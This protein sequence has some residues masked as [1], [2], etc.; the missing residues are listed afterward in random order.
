V[1]AAELLDRCRF[2]DTGDSTSPLALGVSGGADSVAMALLAAASGRPFVIWHVDHGLR[3]T[4][5]DD[6][7]AVE[8]LAGELGVEFELRSVELEP[9]G[10]LESRAR[11]AR[12]DALP[13]DVCVAHSADDRAETVLLNLLRGSGT[14]GVAA[15]FSMV[16][17]PVL[18]L[19]RSELRDVCDRAGVEVVVDEH[20]TDP[21]FRRIR[22]R[23]ELLPLIT[24]IF[25]RDPV[26]L[27]N[28]FA[29]LSGAA[30]DVVAALAADLDPVD[31]EDLRAA[32]PVVAGE[33]L[34]RWIR[35][36]TG[37]TYV[38][39]AASVERVMAVVTGSA[40]A[41]E[42]VGGHRVSRSAG[43]LSIS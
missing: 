26:P 39:D 36:E 14:S 23:T 27:L 13:A 30:T 42:V 34:R 9:G 25:E 31:V 6:A 16:H 11:T 1:V 40:I 5:G 15:R 8:R 17:R 29:D 32:A 10:D 28:R 7:R 22:V 21:S 43:R 3:P 12:Y 37:S 19:R 18:G 41:A 2:P 35:S 33:A 20:N 38:V 4:S 24:D